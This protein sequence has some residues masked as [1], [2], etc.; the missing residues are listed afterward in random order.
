MIF[1]AETRCN[2]EKR[3]QMLKNLGFDNTKV[4]PSVGGSGG[5]V[6]AW[7]SNTVYAI[8]H[9]NHR[10]LLWENLKSLSA[11][12]SK[13]W[14]VIGDFN[15]IISTNERIGGGRGNIQRMNWFQQQIDGCG[16]FDLGFSGSKYTWKGPK[17]NGYARLYERLDRALG[18][19]SFLTNMADCFVKILPRICFSDHSPIVLQFFQKSFSNSRPFRF[20]A[21]WLAHENFTDFLNLNWVDDIDINDALLS[22]RDSLVVWNKEV[23]SVIEKKKKHILA[24]LNGIQNSSSYPY[25]SF[26]CN[27]EDSLQN[28]LESVLKLEEIK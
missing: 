27:L 13:P 15:N 5:L 10:Q 26:L 8:P 22:L 16:L 21:M 23:F 18:N 6:A 11:S 19:S 20:E 4:V 25:S 24:R 14:T 2:K 3:F 9:S 17:V 28:E 12:V 1:L 7:K